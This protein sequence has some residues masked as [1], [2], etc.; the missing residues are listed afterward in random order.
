MSQL[1]VNGTNLGDSINAYLATLNPQQRTAERNGNGALV[2]ETLPDKWKVDVEWKF[3]K[4]QSYYDRFNFLKTLTRINFTVQF[5]AP[6]GAIETA[7]MYISPISA[8]MLQFNWGAAGMW[9]KLKTS[10]VEV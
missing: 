7:T 1:T 6:T 5:A 8:N 2:R 9:D 10:F 4:P 3:D